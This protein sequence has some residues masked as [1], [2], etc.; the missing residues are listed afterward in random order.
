MEPRIVERDQILLAGMGFYGDP[1]ASSAG[2]TEEN[3]IGRLW[4]RFMAFWRAEGARLP[5]LADPSVMYEVHIEHPETQAKGHYEV[6]AGVEVSQLSGLPAQLLVKVL[7]SN[8]YAVFTMAGSEI[9]SDWGPRIYGEW[10]PGSGYEGV[11]GYV[12]ELYDERFKGIGRL[13]ESVLDVYIPVR[14][15]D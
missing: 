7:P 12:F 9:G 6:F 15:K 4:N 1:F 10:M 2:W 11:P 13:E 5:H 14:R 3:E 8:L